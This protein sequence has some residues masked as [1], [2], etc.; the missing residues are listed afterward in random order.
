[1]AISR[2][3][4]TPVSLCIYKDQPKCSRPACLLLCLDTG[5]QPARLQASHCPMTGWQQL[6]STSPVLFRLQSK[7]LTPNP[8]LKGKKF[9]SVG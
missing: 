8:M 3:K 2:T 9:L 7:M 1:M 6:N 4:V 5:G